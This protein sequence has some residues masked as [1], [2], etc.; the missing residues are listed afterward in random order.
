MRGNKSANAFGDTKPA[1]SAT[2]ELSGLI[3][4]PNRFC[5]LISGSPL[6]IGGKQSLG[7][8]E[9]LQLCYPHSGAGKQCGL[10]QMDG[11]LACRT[12]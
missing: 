3:A 4:D 5:S 1:M 11:A 8:L 10:A 6:P 2:K 9:R 12:L 7:Q